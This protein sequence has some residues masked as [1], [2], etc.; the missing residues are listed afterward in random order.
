MEYARFPALYCCCSEAVVRAI[1]RDIFRVAGVDVADLQEGAQ[2]QLVEIDW[3]GEPIDMI[4]GA[5][6]LDAG[7]TADYPIHSDHLQTQHAATKWH[8]AGAPGVLCRSASLARFGF[9][10]WT[11]HHARW[12]ELTVYT[13]N[14]SPRPS[15]LRRRDDLDW[16]GL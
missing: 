2:P 12:S 6:I 16:L 13:D 5:A 15:L 8:E 7:F 14:S 11:G 4:T 3:T 9:S 1:V 10:D